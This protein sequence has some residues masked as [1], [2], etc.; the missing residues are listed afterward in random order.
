M[1]SKKPKCVACKKRTDIVGR[2]DCSACYQVNYRLV[3]LRRTTWAEL[4]KKGL[5]I[6]PGQK[7]ITGS[8]TYQAATAGKK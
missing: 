7:N 5:A 8:K 6:P 2:G 4:E 3:E 1:R